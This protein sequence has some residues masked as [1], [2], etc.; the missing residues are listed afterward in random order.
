MKHKL[1]WILVVS[2]VIFSLTACSL[3]KDEAGPLKP[4]ATQ[5]AVEGKPKIRS[6]E[7][8]EPRVVT[9]N[10]HRVTL[11]T[12]DERMNFQI[13]DVETYAYRFFEKLEYENVAIEAEVENFGD[14]TNG[15]ALVCRASTK[16]WYEFRIS[17][18]GKY[19]VYRYEQSLKESGKNPY[20]LIMNGAA[21]ALNAGVRKK[22]KISFI[23]EDNKLKPF[24]NDKEIKSPNKPFEDDTFSSGQAGIGAMSYQATPVKVEFLWVSI[25]KP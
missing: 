23:C 17:S 21:T 20:V 5:P 16:G 6:E 14:T 7:W 8:S 19:D 22:N 11:T 12:E 18:S 1:F 15:I 3:G 24:I 25:K 4:E 9:G 13:D 2:L 10:A